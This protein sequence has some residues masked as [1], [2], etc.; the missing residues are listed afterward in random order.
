MANQ[1][2]SAGVGSQARSR[3]GNSEGGVCAARARARPSTALGAASLA[4]KPRRERGE[5]RVQI[6]SSVYPTSEKRKG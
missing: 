1:K 5:R 4:V 6:P 3:T 2:Q